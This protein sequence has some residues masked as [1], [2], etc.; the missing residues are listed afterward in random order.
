MKYI[1]LALAFALLSQHLVD[2][3]AAPNEIVGHAIVRDD[4][5]L[6][7][8]NRVIHLFG[9]YIPP[10]NR[11]CRKWENPVRCSSRAGLSLDFR[12]SGFIRCYPKYEN[13]DGSLTAVCYVDRTT[14]DTG[15]DLA[16]YLIQQGWALAT[17]DAPFEYSALERIAENQGL[18][19]WGFQVDAFSRRPFGARHWHRDRD[20]RR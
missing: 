9:I 11:E 14:F 15:E 8:K 18:G 2:S 12:V 19:V 5:T 13:A 20:G 16:A 1:C 3:R 10:T 6:L 17:P 7:I 4:A